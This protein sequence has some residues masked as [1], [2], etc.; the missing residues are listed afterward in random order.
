MQLITSPWIRILL[1]AAL[2][3]LSLSL[4]SGGSGCE[5]TG[6][7]MRRVVPPGTQGVFVIESLEK[8][9]AAAASFLAGVEGASGL[10]ELVDA[11]YGVDLSKPEGLA[12]VGIDGDGG[13]AVF[14]AGPGL[15]FA[16]SVYDA[17]LWESL[18]L[19]RARLLGAKV[20]QQS[21]G[22]TVARSGSGPKDL[23]LVW[24]VTHDGIGLAV[25]TPHDADAQALFRELSK[26]RGGFFQGDRAKEARTLVDAKGPKVWMAGTWTPP[27]PENTLPLI[28]ETQLRGPILGLSRWSAG[29]S[30]AGDRVSMRARGKVT[31]D[32]ETFPTS[33]FTSKSPRTAFEELLP[34]MSTIAVRTRTGLREVVGSIPS[35]V[36]SRILPDHMPTVDNLPLPPPAELLEILDGNLMVGFLGLDDDVLLTQ[37]ANPRLRRELQLQMVHLVVGVGVTDVNK[38]REMLAASVEGAKKQGFAVAEVGKDTAGLE[39]YSFVTRRRLY[40]LSKK[41]KKKPPPVPPRTYAMLLSDKHKALLL[42]TGRGE[43]ARFL[44]VARG[45]A[46]PLGSL[47]AP[48]TTGSTPSNP[49]ARAAITGE[50]NQAAIVAT[51]TRI[52]RELADKGVPP[53]FLKMLSDLHIVGLTLNVGTDEVRMALDVQL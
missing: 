20:V 18:M 26:G 46:L 23:R 51:P 37:L 14:R 5:R 32:K 31:L 4:G 1:G 39:G 42:V 43:V 27:Y 41:Q 12:Q 52:A 15:A 45:A 21:P 38:A 35:F 50:G 22:E 7:D 16:M 10:L 36:L 44:D 24:G 17:R 48:T 28:L 47:E 11:R 53:F 6:G 9:R 2:I 13:V 19:S 25:V 49:V 33:W 3:A 30:I 8:A 34:R 40:R 29:L